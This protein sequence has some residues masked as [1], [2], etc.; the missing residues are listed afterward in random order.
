VPPLATP[1]P[2]APPATIAASPAVR[3]FIDRAR[4]VQGFELDANTAR[5]V[6]GICRRLDGLPLAIELAARIGLLDPPAL[7]RRLEQRL[8]SHSKAAGARGITVPGALSLLTTGA[9]DLP[10]RQQ[11]LRA[12]LAWSCDLLEPADRILLRTLGIFAGGW[13]IEAAEAVSA[14]IDLPAATVL[15]RLQVL[16]DSSLV[17]RLDDFRSEPRFGMLETV[18]EYALEQMEAS[19]ERGDRSRRQRCIAWAWPNKRSPTSAAPTRVAGSIDWTAN[20]TISGSR[21][22]GHTRVASWRLDCGLRLRSACF[23]RSAA[24]YARCTN[25]WRR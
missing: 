18:R 24:T 7:L 9:R 19:D 1:D 22:R 2:T 17:Q 8:D 15:D 12:A 3:L 13:T 21:W 10:E 20:S 23:A 4:E 5:A 16:V 11:T 25:D 14:G 6:A